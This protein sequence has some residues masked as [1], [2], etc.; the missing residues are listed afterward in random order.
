MIPLQKNIE[1]KARLHSLPAASE[2]AVR[3]ATASLGVQR[4]VDTYC[5][6]DFS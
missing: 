2:I 5:R 3:V 6:P 4:Q 1:L